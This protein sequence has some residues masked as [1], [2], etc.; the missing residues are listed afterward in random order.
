MPIPT[1]AL[2]VVETLTLSVHELVA[3]VAPFRICRKESSMVNLV[4]RLSIVVCL[5]LLGCSSASVLEPN[6]AGVGA[7]DGV[8][9][10]DGVALS[11][12]IQLAG[13]ASK[14]VAQAS[15][16]I[17]MVLAQSEETGEIYRGTTDGDGDFEIDIPGSELGNTFMVTILGPD[18]KAVG[19]VLF[20]IAGDDGLAGLALERDA[21]LGTIEIPDDPAQ[22][23]IE[24]GDDGDV[25][26]LVDDEVT[27][28]LDEDG[29][30]IGLDSFGKGAA[31]QSDGDEADQAVDNDR[32]GLIDVVD[33][34]DDGDGVVDDFEGGGDPGGPAGDVRFGFFMNLKIY[35]PDAPTFYAG[36]E[37]E[38]A[39]ALAEHTIITVECQAEPQATRQ[40]TAVR[41][42]ETPGPAYMPTADHVLE[43]STG[44][45][46]QNWKDAGYAFVEEADRFDAFVRPNTVMEAGDTITVEVTFDDGTTEQYSRM[47]NFVFKNIPKL[48]RYGAAGELTE[49]D[50]ADANVDGTDQK[51]ILFDGTQDL[52]LVFN[53]PVDELGNYLTQLD[54][55]SFAIFYTDASGTQLNDQ[56]D[57]EAMW[58][59]PPSGW[60]VRGTYTVQ[61]NELTLA[62]DN[63]YT[64]T[65]PKEL[66][67]DAITT[68]TAD[69]LP[70]DYYKIDITA[71]TSS[72]NAAVMLAF[73]KQ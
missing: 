37:A 9:A 12:T 1:V 53:P 23:A 42:L 59:S 11:G 16:P 72:G 8:G 15:A 3:T 26:D 31:A 57:G 25:D 50:V 22:D 63:T 44:L 64:V 5:A 20:G 51:P 62:A 14:A 52:V 69:E 19:P 27:T 48:V 28:R 43:G 40:M 4:K 54:Y 38:I 21:S 58:P 49:F 45:E 17:Y 61:Q 39:A 34:D 29:V 24:P 33:A 70:V 55:Y 68:T 35:S 18:G 7:T 41:A 46:Y 36:S 65:L 6:A 32:D 56:M 2:H 71:E 13:G 67:A 10:A 60:N 30:P 66:F 73:T 47:V